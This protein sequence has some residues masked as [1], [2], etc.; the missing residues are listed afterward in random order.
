MVFCETQAHTFVYKDGIITKQKVSMQSRNQSIFRLKKK[1]LL[2]NRF[3]ALILRIRKQ[4][5]TSC[6][7]LTEHGYLILKAAW[8]FSGYC[9]N[10]R[11]SFNFAVL[12]WGKF[13]DIFILS[14]LSSSLYTLFL[15]FNS[16]QKHPLK[17][18]FHIWMECLLRINNISVSKNVSQ[19]PWCEPIFI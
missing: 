17:C 15:F 2:L 18:F 12:Q 13:R 1:N 4:T 7:Q 6:T 11:S 19:T 8:A 10:W 9:R 3:P 14:A 16:F 5:L